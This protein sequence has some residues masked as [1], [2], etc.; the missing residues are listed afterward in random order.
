MT[1]R[2]DTSA[3]FGFLRSSLDAHTMGIFSAAVLLARC[4]QRVAI[5]DEA[6]CGAAASAA[7]M[8]D[9]ENR[10]LIKTWLRDNG[11][12]RLGFSYRLDP[13]SGAE[14]FSRLVE[15]LRSE[16]MFSG[17]SGHLQAVYFAGLP[18][19]CEMV[20]AGIPDVA[21]FFSGD[22]NAL[23]TLKILGVPQTLLP[24]AVSAGLAYDEDRLAFG[25][26][27]VRKRIYMSVQP[28]ERGSY[29]L[30]GSRHDTLT[31]RLAHGLK[32]RLPPLMRAHMGPYLP[33]RKEAVALFLKWTRELASAGLLD[34]LSIGSS[35]L[36]QSAFGEDWE[37][38]PNGGGVPINSRDEFAAAWEAARP[39]LVRAY[40]GARDI[41]R[42]ARMH[43]ETINMA[44][45]ALSLWWFCQIDGRGP[46]DV[47]ENLEQHVAALKFIAARGK[48]FEPNV[49]HH[50]SFRGGDDVTYV[51]SAVLAA[52]LAKSLGVRHLILQ[53]M[54]GTPKGT[55]GIQ[56]LA[57]SRAMLLLTREL[58]D[59]R[60]RVIFQPR[61][62]LD[63]F[64]TDLEEARA[65]LAA[66]TALMDDIE[67]LSPESPPLI[68]VVSYCEASHL[69]DPSAIN[70]SIRI[71][72]QALE[73][74]RML[75]Q[76]GEI[77]DMS[78][79][80]ETEARMA[81]LLAD[82]RTVLK[83]IEENVPEYLSAEGLY[84]VFTGGF[85]PAPGL[86]EC[87][88][89]FHKAT[90]WQTRLIDGAVVVVDEHG[91]HVP[92]GERMR[93]TVSDLMF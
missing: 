89:E 9:P 59:D 50:F 68:H 16:G 46:Y 82:A 38:R 78:R 3:C 42:M 54:L 56:D 81:S 74:Y 27:L 48:P 35:Q 37:G 63:S 33:D 21:G 7:T 62:G 71:T 6:V 65:R 79:H 92:V 23:D 32:H 73:E 93:R 39:M 20:R 10:A 75:R 13:R 86:W 11:V 76:R 70:E 64:S 40:A 85:L 69:A 1:R 88:R 12:T 72:R 55:W 58:E 4:G 57:K 91:R 22:E 66:S 25:R 29:A 77:D 24:R 43:E 28:V 83:T 17:R 36:T 8:E 52:R 45:H 49:P 47:R 84:R 41:A 5:A 15:L 44:W 31:A 2:P 18:A 51:V 26:D 14:I 53:N 19:A 87:R 90:R 67:P 80:P 34:V 61:A 30:F 60:F